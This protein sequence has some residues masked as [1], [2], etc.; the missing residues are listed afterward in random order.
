MKV[1]VV[2]KN[3]LNNYQLL[4]FQNGY[5]VPYKT[6]SGY[7]VN[8][9]P[10]KVKDWSI[11]ENSLEVLQIDQTK[12][13]DIKVIGMSYLQFLIEVAIPSDEQNKND[14]D[15]FMDLSHKFGNILIMSLGEEY[16]NI[17]YDNDKPMIVLCD[18]DGIIKG[19]ITP[20]EFNDISEIILFY[21]I[22]DYDD[23]KFS[24]DV[25]ELMNEYYKL[26]Y[27]D[28]NMPTLEEKKSYLLGKTGNTL[29]EVNE[30]NYR[31]FSMIYDSLVSTDL[32]FGNKIIQA[33]EKYKVEGEIKY[34]LY[35]KKKD[36]LDEI[37]TSKEGFENKI[38]SVNG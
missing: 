14:I 27:S 6:K 28:V 10:I 26:K 36:K 1:I 13:N 15:L 4:Y 32:Y 8:I 20:K 37:F 9:K 35:E 25:K 30:M 22:H 34:P 23:R 24:D 21:N 2:E 16:I 3:K 33:S 18:E 19:K 29:N 5:D 12:A 17:Q 11:F 31:T 38:N 7:T